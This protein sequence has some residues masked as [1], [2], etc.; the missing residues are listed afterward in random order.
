MAIVDEAYENIGLR[1]GLQFESL[2]LPKLPASLIIRNQPMVNSLND[3]A[4]CCYSILPRT[5]ET[6]HLT[7]SLAI[8]IL[9]GSHERVGFSN[10][11][12]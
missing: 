3:M 8:A 12:F 2:Y 6:S 11:M 5:I 10:F 4:R 1:V 9:S 7:T